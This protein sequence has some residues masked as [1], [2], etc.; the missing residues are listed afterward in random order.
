MFGP[1]DY[2]LIV[3]RR[4][5]S[6]SHQ[7]EA[8][9]LDVLVDLLNFFVAQKACPGGHALIFPALQRDGEK[10]LW[11]HCCHETLQIRRQRAFGDVSPVTTEAVRVVKLITMEDS[12]RDF[13]VAPFHEDWKIK[14]YIL[15]L[16]GIGVLFRFRLLTGQRHRKVQAHNERREQ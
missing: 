8:P 4:W 6:S 10:V 7:F 3:F 14:R 1:P 15:A 11:L 12:F 5:S 16:D 9:Y 2:G 13:L